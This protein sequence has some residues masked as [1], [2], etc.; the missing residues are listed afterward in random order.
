MIHAVDSWGSVSVTTRLASLRRQP[1]SKQ[2]TKVGKARAGGDVS[3]QDE[4]T[5]GVGESGLQALRSASF[6]DSRAKIKEAH[7]HSST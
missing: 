5:G 6:I 2:G 4:L 7:F 1:K 3:Q